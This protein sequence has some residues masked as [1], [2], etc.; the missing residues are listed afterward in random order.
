LKHKHVEHRFTVAAIE[1]FI[2]ERRNA[3]ALEFKL[4]YRVFNVKET[5]ILNE[6]GQLVE[7]QEPTLHE[8]A[9]LVVLGNCFFDEDT[10]VS[11]ELSLTEID[12]LALSG[13][14][15]VGLGVHFLSATATIG[16]RKIAHKVKRPITQI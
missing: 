2:T 13:Q 8:E 5:Q 10:N 9:L 16:R 1:A 12:C 14:R 6:S 4:S 7:L 15:I 3:L 11:S